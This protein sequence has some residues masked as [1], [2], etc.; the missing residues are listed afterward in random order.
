[1]IRVEAIRG[2]VVPFHWYFTEFGLT[3]T[4]IRNAHIHVEVRDEDTE[5]ARFSNL[6]GGVAAD[7]RKRRFTAMVK[8]KGFDTGVHNV[9]VDVLHGNGSNVRKP[10]HTLVIAKG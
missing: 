4:S 8:T 2:E 6:T 10:T 7:I 1:M 5:V 3:E 9:W